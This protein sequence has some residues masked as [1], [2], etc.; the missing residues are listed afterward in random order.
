MS[1]H[2]SFRL[3]PMCGAIRVLTFGLLALPV[4]LGVS[5]L[6]HLPALRGELGFAARVGVG[7]LWGGFGWLWTSRRGLIDMYV[8]RGDGL[9]MVERLAGR[10]LLITPEHPDEFSRALASHLAAPQ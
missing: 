1:Q 8:S 3:A 4:V 5:F 10:P 9:L 2:R 7:G 6:L